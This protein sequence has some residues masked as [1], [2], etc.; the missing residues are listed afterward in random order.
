MQY[1][2]IDKEIISYLQLAHGAWNLVVMLLFW[3]QAWLGLKIRKARRVP[4]GALPFPVIRRHRKSGPVFAGMALFGYLFGIVIVVLH[5]GHL[6]K[7]PA[8]FLTGTALM[9]I[10]ISSIM[11]SRKI[12]GQQSPYRTAHFVAGIFLLVLYPVQI[13]LGLGVLF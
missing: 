11:F 5:E 13:L 10:I 2:L 3:Q 4:G 1:P 9:A 6:F 7:H 8:H 12:Q